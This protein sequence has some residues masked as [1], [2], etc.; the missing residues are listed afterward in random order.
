[1][2]VAEVVQV[3]LADTVVVELVAAV[4]EVLKGKMLL[5]D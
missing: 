1:M 5:M 2:L 4:M 3:I